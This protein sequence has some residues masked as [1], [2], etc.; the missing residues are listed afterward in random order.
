MTPRMS[1]VLS[2]NRDAFSCSEPALAQYPPS[3]PESLPSSTRPSARVSTVLSLLNDHRKGYLES[4]WT[5]LDLSPDDYDQ[6]W[7]VLATDTPL[8]DHFVDKVRF[9]IVLHSSCLDF[10]YTQ[11]AIGTTGLHMNLRLTCECQPRPTTF[12]LSLL[13]RKSNLS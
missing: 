8:K 13:W 7:T 9:V 4:R 3:P 10:A 12:S 2:D 5:A 11:G 1:R 6:L